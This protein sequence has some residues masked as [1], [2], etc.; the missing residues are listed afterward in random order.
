M[1]VVHAGTVNPNTPE[2]D[3]QPTVLHEVGVSH[4]DAMIIVR[5]MA[6]DPLDAMDRVRAMSEQEVL[7][8]AVKTEAA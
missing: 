7:A 2:S 5:L 4:D 6:T 8:I 3:L 1:R